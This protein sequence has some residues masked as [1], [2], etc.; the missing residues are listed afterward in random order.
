MVRLTL[1]K[2]L[3]Q[4]HEDVVTLAKELWKI[5]DTARREREM[6]AILVQYEGV[7]HYLFGVYES[8]AQVEKDLSEKGNL[9]FLTSLDKYKVLRLSS[10][11]I[12]KDEPT[13][14][15]DFR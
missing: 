14:L 8:I 15:F 12:W 3:E 5:I 7:G 4:E 6:Y 2:V 9:K 11:S 1:L 13:E 10:S